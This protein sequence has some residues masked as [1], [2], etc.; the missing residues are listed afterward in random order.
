MLSFG[1][2]G[3]SALYRWHELPEG[4]G[5][6]SQGILRLWLEGRGLREVARMYHTDRK[7]VRPNCAGPRAYGPDLDGDAGQVTDELLAADRGR[8]ADSTGGQKSGG[9]SGRHFAC[10]C[11]ALQHD[12]IF[13][14]TSETRSARWSFR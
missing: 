8:S 1:F 4:V 13:P 6:R 11:Q 7:T 9:F 2:S 14:S 12:Q 5:V 10:R 3:C